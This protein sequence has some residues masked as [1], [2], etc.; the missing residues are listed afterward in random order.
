MQTFEEYLASVHAET[1]KGMDDDMP[2]DFSNWLTN[3]QVG[4]WLKYAEDWKNNY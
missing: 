4:E 2:D 1:Y 3:L